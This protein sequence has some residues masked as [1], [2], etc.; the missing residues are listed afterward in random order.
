MKRFQFLIL[1]LLVCSAVS[2]DAR[3]A[4]LI[5]FGSGPVAAGYNSYAATNAAPDPA[6][7]AYTAAQTTF[8]TGA[9]VD[10]DALLNNVVLT[11]NVPANV[12]RVINR[13]PD[14]TN[15]SLNPDLFRDWIAV[16][17]LASQPET[18]LRVTISGLPDGIYNWKSYHHDLADQTGLM[19]VTLTGSGPAV[20][21][22]VDIS[23]G[24]DIVTNV[25][26]A[27]FAG[28]TTATNTPVEFNSSFTISGGSPVLF[29][30][31]PQ[32]P[33]NTAALAPNQFQSVNFTA[34]N[35]VEITLIPE[36]STALLGLL[37]L[38]ALAGVRRFRC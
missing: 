26:N 12:F 37:G 10:V 7:V 22:T 15:D 23:N 8:A 9:T 28:D 24:N 29:T 6:A 36:P 5:D 17:Q 18:V 1:A 11:S 20:A 38:S 4:F 13:T 35:G 19:D 16:T 14:G 33:I 21:G 2:S 27:P 30:I 34:L 25:N 32:S 31:S 3:A